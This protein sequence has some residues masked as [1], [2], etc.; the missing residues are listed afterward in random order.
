MGISDALQFFLNGAEL[1]QNSVNSGNLTNHRSMN[2][3]QFKDPVSQMCL[4][5]TVVASWSLT[6]ELVGS[7]PFT[8]MTNIFVTEFAEFSETFRENS[9]VSEVN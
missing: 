7:S 2:W 1:S 5:D 4:A 8:T 9:T 3:A 6:Q